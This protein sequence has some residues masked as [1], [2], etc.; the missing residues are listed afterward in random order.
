IAKRCHKYYFEKRIMQMPPMPF[1]YSPSQLSNPQPSASCKPDWAIEMLDGMKEM[2]KELTKLGS[3]EKTLGTLTIKINQLE[4]KVASMETVVSNC[5]KS[6]EFLSKSYDSQSKELKHA[7]DDIKTLKKQCDSFEKQ[8][9]EQNMSK[10]KLENK[11]TDLEARSM[12]ENLLFHGI[13]ETPNE[14]CEVKVKEFMVSELSFDENSVNSITLDRVH[15]IGRGPRGPGFTRPIVAKFHKYS[16]RERVRDAGYT[17]RQE[18]QIKNMSVK[19]QLPYDVIQKRKELNSVYE[20]AKKDGKDPKFNMGKLF[21][22]GREYVP[23]N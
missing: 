15:R 10:S 3:I 1:S 18:L 7:A 19:P 6:S 23:P 8:V 16:D 17:K 9:Q 20:Q 12:R 21:I 4:N 14:N 5:E 11:I 22:N 13:Q 2:R